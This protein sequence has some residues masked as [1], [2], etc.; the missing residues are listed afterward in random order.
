MLTRQKDDDGLGVFLK[1]DGQALRFWHS[2]VDEGFDALLVGY[3][4]EGKGAVI[5]IN[6]NEDSDA[7][8]QIIKAVAKEYHWP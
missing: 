8:P 6:K 2:G 7:V 3:A 4:G 1:G 5:L